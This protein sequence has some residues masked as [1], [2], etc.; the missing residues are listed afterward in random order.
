MDT[1]EGEVTKITPCSPG[2]EGA[3]EKTWTDVNSED[4]LEPLLGLKDF[5]QAIGVNRPT[6][7]Q[8]DIA[9]HIAFTEQMGIE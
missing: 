5:E 4:L 6:V 9:K 7:T 2:A 3:V 8:A 1:P